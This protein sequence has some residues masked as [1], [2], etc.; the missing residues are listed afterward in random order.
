MLPDTAKRLLDEPT[1]VH[2]A[3]LDDGR[4]HVTPVWADRDGD[5]IRVNTA[6]GRIKPRAVRDDPSVAISMTDN[7]DPYTRVSIQGR[8]VELVH[9]GARDHIDA[10][11]KK[12]LDR[13]RYP[14]PTDEQRVILLIEPHQVHAG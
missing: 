4:P 1:I 2:L 6:E 5:T 8:V 7:D 9:E 11:A 14:G 12:Y 10:L 13:D 3:V